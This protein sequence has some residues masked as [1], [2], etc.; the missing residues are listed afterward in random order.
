MSSNNIPK[1]RAALPAVKCA[2]KHSM[3]PPPYRSKK[4]ACR[5]NIL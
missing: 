2:P 3:K 4:A 5:Q 1:L